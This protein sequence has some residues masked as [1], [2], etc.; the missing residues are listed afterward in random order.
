MSKD[1]LNRSLKQE[2][3]MGVLNRKVS[4]LII[5]GR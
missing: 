5:G 1:S 3:I 2:E 4:L